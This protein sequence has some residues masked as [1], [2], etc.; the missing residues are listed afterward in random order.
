MLR[1]AFF[2][3][4]I[5]VRLSDAANDLIDFGATWKL[6]VCCKWCPVA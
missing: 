4:S 1:G 6:W 3:V 2:H 5:R